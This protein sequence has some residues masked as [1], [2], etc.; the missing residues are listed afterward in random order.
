M[1]NPYTLTSPCKKCPF[2][3]DVDSYL[4]P[5]RVEEIAASLNSGS[6]FTCHQTTDPVEDEDGNV[7]MVS[8]KRARA[9]AGALATLENQGTPTQSM[10]I[11]ERLGMYDSARIADAPVYDSLAEWVRAKNGVQTVTSSEG[12]VLEFQHCEVVSMNCEDPAGYGTASGAVENSDE[13]TCNP[14]ED[15]CESCGNLMC[16]SCR[17]EGYNLCVDCEEG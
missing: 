16:E 8:G 13:P 6:D 11:A 7:E 2:R 17:S 15:A 12:E 14:L 3:T 5:E 1:S 4:R 10:R 9:C